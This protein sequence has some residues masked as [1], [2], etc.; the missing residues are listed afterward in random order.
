MSM[1][2]QALYAPDTGKVNFKKERIEPVLG[3]HMLPGYGESRMSCGGI[4]FLV[5]C[6]DCGHS[7]YV[8][9]HCDRKE[10]PICYT[11]WATRRARV[12]TDRV[13]E[14]YREMARKYRPSHVS[15]SAPKS[16]RSLPYEKVLQLGLSVMKKA[17]PYGGGGL[18]VGHPW[19]FRDYNGDEVQWK[20]CDL[21]SEAEGPIIESLAVYEPHLHFVVFGW[22][23]PGDEIYKETGWVLHKIDDL[24]EDLDVLMC[25]RYELTHTGIHPN[26]H[27]LRWWGNLC[28]NNFV[29][30]SEKK[31]LEYPPCPEC[32]GKLWSYSLRTNYR[33]LYRIEV[34][35]RHYRFKVYQKQ[36]VKVKRYK[37]LLPASLRHKGRWE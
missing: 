31:V 26:H 25:V 8:K 32:G 23:K 28:Y 3:G 30:W 4:R 9:D 27:A 36:L 37:H 12:A 22:L 35:K 21:N 18:Y 19:R 1:S 15:L 10:C 7:F 20:H 17:L 13:E 2:G 5:K 11:S 34:T 29:C 14:A 33:E 16:V 24:P 6:E